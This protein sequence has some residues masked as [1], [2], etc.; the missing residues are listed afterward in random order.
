MNVLLIA[1]SL[2][3]VTA[4]LLPPAAAAQDLPAVAAASDLKFA[5]DEAASQFRAETGMIVRPVYGSSGNF[6]QQIQQGAPF[7][8]FMS[9]DE[10][11]VFE[12]ARRGLTVDDGVLYAI[13][14]IV[15][16]VPSASPLRAADGLE[17]VRLAQA[18]GRL[19][20]FAIANPD[21]APYGRA[22]RAALRRAGIWEALQPHLVL[23][24]NVSQAAQFTASGSVQA[25]IFALSLAMAPAIA[26]TGNYVIL[27]EDSAEPLRQRMVLTRRA[28]K[29]ARAFYTWL[30]G[31]EGRTVLKRYG[32]GLPPG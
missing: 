21:H 19:R 26:R 20:K 30:A 6:M 29:T 15:L 10:S 1:R 7:E 2:A 23:G 3:L 16:F 17:G 13:G 8:L 14:R 32:F 25:G 9:A 18:D 12:L 11:L 4:L 28:G 24:E 27:P 31:A 22:A 5:L